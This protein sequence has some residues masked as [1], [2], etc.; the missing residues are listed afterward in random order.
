MRAMWK[1]SI[2]FGLV[3]IPVAFYKATEG[4]DIKLH[5]AHKADGGAI[6]QKRFCGMCAEEV[7]F[8]DIGKSLELAGGVRVMLTDDDLATIAGGERSQA[9]EVVKFVHASEVDVK[10]YADTYYT[11]PS[12]GGDKAYALLRDALAAEGQVGLIKITLRA[13]SK[14]KLAM[15]RPEGDMLVVTTLLWPE[16]VRVPDF[17]FL[18]AGSPTA[19][20]AEMKMAAGLIKAMS[21]VFDPAEFR[22]DNRERLELLAEAKASGT[23]LPPPPERPEASAGMDL[24]AALKASIDD[25]KKAKRGGKAA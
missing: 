7:P 23:P 4:T 1:G 19:S 8:A 14:E 22:D 24:A 16:E 13:G 10:L 12:G 3:M 20:A 5:M 11:E 18:D 15:L 2:Q 6:S 25:K 9:A 17:A 21:G